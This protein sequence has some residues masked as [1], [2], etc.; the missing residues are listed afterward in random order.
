MKE[1]HN[2]TPAGER[3]IRKAT[4]DETIAE[5]FPTSD[6][7]SSLP[8]TDEPVARPTPLAE[9]AQQHGRAF[10]LVARRSDRRYTAHRHS[11]QRS[12]LTT[13]WRTQ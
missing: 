6:P 12:P 9:P 1:G 13:Q 7:A 10:C 2:H 11:W 5:S 8:N 4:L 3:R